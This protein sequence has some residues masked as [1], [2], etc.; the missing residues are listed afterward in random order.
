MTTSLRT[1]LEHLLDGWSADVPAAWRQILSGVQLDFAAVDAA[2]TLESSETIWPGRKAAPPPGSPAGAHIFHA[3]DGVS[4]QAVRVVVIGQDPYLHV[5]QATGR[6]FEQGDLKDWLGDPS[7]APSLRR[8][9]QCVAELRTS[10]AGY[11]TDATGWRRVVDEVRAAHLTLEH[12][13]RALWDR[14]ASHGVLFLNA[15]LTFSRFDN[16]VRLRGH[17]PLWRPVWQ[18]IVTHLV[19]RHGRSLVAVAWGADAAH[20][21]EDVRLKS[22][23]EAAGTWQQT[24][25][26]IHAPHPNAQPKA[27]GTSPFLQTNRLQ[28]IDATLTRLGGTAVNW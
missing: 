27:K 9:V 19:A 15:A 5:S 13:P 24:V 28:E 8:I 20:V 3:L 23:A 22:L 2:L 26:V 11:R 16:A 25:D 17:R 4:P 7:V 18:A 1:A 14:W 12:D 21:L 6:A 10:D